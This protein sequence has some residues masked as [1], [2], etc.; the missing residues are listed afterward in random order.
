VSPGGPPLAG[1]FGARPHAAVT[2]DYWRCLTRP[3]ALLQLWLRDDPPWVPPVLDEEFPDPFGPT[4]SSQPEPPAPAEPRYC[5]WRLPSTRKRRLLACAFARLL[6]RLW[7]GSHWTAEQTAALAGF[8][9]TGEAVADG[10]WVPPMKPDPMD[11]HLEV[12]QGM[13]DGLRE[14]RRGV[15]HTRGDLPGA[16]FHSRRAEYRI[17][18]DQ[19]CVRACQ[20]TADAADLDYYG[21]FQSSSELSGMVDTVSRCLAL[22]L[23][24]RTNRLDEAALDRA[25]PEQAA[26]LAPLGRC[27]SGPPRPTAGGPPPPR[28]FDRRWAAWQDSTPLHVAQSI[29]QDRRFADLP[30]LADALEEAGCMDADLLTH[31][32]EPGPHARGCWAL[33]LVLGKEDA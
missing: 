3:H 14:Q 27:A 16:Y 20:H 5:N 2:P 30:V 15:S 18:R 12:L 32:R 8:V 9:E 26:R 24:Y 21:R 11:R 1:L 25:V 6:E 10:T 28:A 19:A 13:R 17:R 7:V 29:Y 33:D 23:C 31:L 4:S 22:D